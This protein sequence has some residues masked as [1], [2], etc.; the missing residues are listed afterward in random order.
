MTVTVDKPSFNNVTLGLLKGYLVD[1]KKMI[2]RGECLHVRHATH[3]LNLIMSNGLK[4]VNQSVTWVRT[5][6]R[7]VRSS[8][9]IKKFKVAI[10]V[11]CITCKK[12]ISLDVS[13]RWNSTF[14][15]LKVA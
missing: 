2:F 5:V 15:M 14:L 1:V 10:E 4:D 11:A 7:F 3:F 8:L 9:S 12:D 6:V 13:T